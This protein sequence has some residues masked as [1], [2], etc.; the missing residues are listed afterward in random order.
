VIRRYYR[1]LSDGAPPPVD[2]LAGRDAVA[3]LEEITRRLTH[4]RDVTT[5][6]NGAEQEL[7]S[8]PWIS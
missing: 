7:G 2:G 4:E 5:R 3:L 1:S 8:R 6:A